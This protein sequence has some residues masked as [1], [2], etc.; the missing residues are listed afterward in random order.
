MFRVIANT[1]NEFAFSTQSTVVKVWKICLKLCTYI[2]KKMRI[3]S[4]VEKIRAISNFE[5]C[6]LRLM[7]D[8]KL[9]LSINLKLYTNVTGILLA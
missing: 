6:W 7:L 8:G 5:I 3:C 9:M 4:L 2:Q 1:E